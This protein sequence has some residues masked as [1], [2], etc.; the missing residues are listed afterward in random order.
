MGS[1]TKIVDVYKSFM[2]NI[3]YIVKVMVGDSKVRK[4]RAK[5]RQ[6]VPKGSQKIAKGNQKGAKGSQKGAKGRPKCIQ[7]SIFG[8]G[9]EKG[10]HWGGCNA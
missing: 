9:R 8:K 3:T 10:G 1:C 7:K 2:E 6:M 5:V 4:W